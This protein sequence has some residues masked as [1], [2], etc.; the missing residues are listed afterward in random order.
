M[1]IAALLAGYSS[2]IKK[3]LPKG[4]AWEQVT[5]A[6][7]GLYTGIATEFCRIDERGRDLLVELDPLTSVEL[8]TDWETLLGLP[9]ECTPLN[10][11]LAERQQQARSKLSDQGGQSAAFFEARADDL[12]FPTTVVSDYH[13]FEVGR[14]TVGEALTNDF[15]IPFT[16][17][18]TVGNTLHD[19]GWRFVFNVN[20]PATVV[21]PFRVGQNVVGD[22]LVEFG[23]ELLECTIKKLKPAHTQPFFTFS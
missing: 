14:S 6:M 4:L 20:S 9:D 1:S 13:P 19:W 3:L 12:G 21:E 11:T 7:P 16:V 15:S 17:G 18:M 8:L 10:L 2:L 23:N 5:E 22:R